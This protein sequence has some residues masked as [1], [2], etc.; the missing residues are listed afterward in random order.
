MPA[1]KK[2]RSSRPKKATKPTSKSQKAGIIFPAA[3]CGT[4]MRRRRLAPR[5]GGDAGVFLAA[6]LQYVCSEVLLTAGDVAHE[7]KKK[8]LKPHHISRA[9][10]NDEEMNKFLNNCQLSAGGSMP[11]VIKEL[12]PKNKM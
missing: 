7:K 2:A 11:N 1:V 12:F 9:I 6:V 3:R 10:R 5:M 4:M 8:Q